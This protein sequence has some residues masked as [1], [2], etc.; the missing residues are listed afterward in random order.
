[1]TGVFSQYSLNVQDLE[2]YFYGTHSHL[3]KVG[4][5]PFLGHLKVGLVT[6]NQITESLSSWDTSVIEQLPWPPCSG[7]HSQKPRWS[8]QWGMKWGGPRGF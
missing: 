3:N 8:P 1:M 5:S 6:M 2:S 7:A 4:G